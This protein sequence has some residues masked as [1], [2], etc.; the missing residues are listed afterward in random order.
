MRP[1]PL[2]HESMNSRQTRLHR[3]TFIFTHAFREFLLFESSA[4][5]FF[6]T[7]SLLAINDKAPITLSGAI[8]GSP[9]QTE[10]K[11]VKEIAKEDRLCKRFFRNDRSLVSCRRMKCRCSIH[12]GHMTFVLVAKIHTM[13]PVATGQLLEASSRK[14]KFMLRIYLQHS[15]KQ[16]RYP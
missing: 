1:A 3:H 10:N 12:C 4:S 9:A 7:V 16:V 13:G 5:D 11:L 15:I 14:T 8:F 2:L 6:R